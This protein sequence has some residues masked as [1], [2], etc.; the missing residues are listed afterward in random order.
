[1]GRKPITK[2]YPNYANFNFLFGVGALMREAE[3]AI[4][5]QIVNKWS[6]V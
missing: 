1:M 6:Y 2:V 4:V 5:A 3:L